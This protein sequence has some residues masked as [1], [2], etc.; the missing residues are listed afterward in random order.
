M[1]KKTYPTNLSK[2]GIFYDSKYTSDRVGVAQVRE[3]CPEKVIRQI[4]VV[5]GSSFW[6][7]SN[8]YQEARNA[9]CLH[10]TIKI[11]VL[12]VMSSISEVI[13]CHVSDLYVTKCFHLIC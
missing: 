1:I 2:R 6:Q 8:Y 9:F 13:S 11:H 5:L 10:S 4:L 3:Y 12:V 7:S